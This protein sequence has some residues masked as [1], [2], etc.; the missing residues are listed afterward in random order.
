MLGRP[1]WSNQEDTS[2]NPEEQPDV[3]GE[4]RTS[5]KKFCGFYTAAGKATNQAFNYLDI[6]LGW[7]WMPRNSPSRPGL[8]SPPLCHRSEHPES[9]V[10]A[11]LTEFGYKSFIRHWDPALGVWMGVF[12]PSMRLLTAGSRT[13]KRPSFQDNTEDISVK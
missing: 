10:K 12:S 6:W 3:A 13:S 11:P 4:N 2:G 5:V 8:Q 1:G 9:S 7:A